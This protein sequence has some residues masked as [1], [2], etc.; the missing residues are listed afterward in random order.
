[1]LLFD[2]AFDVLEGQATD[3]F[4]DPYYEGKTNPHE[5]DFTEDNEIRYSNESAN[6]NLAKFALNFGKK[7]TLNEFNETTPDLTPRVCLANEIKNSD[8]CGLSRGSLL[9]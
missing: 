2:P 6:Y 5:L 1:M 7:G 8:Y 3:T 4:L 9:P